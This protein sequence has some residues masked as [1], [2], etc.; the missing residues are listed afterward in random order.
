MH[1]LE[2]E[3]TQ[4]EADEAAQQEELVRLRAENERLS[5]RIV[6]YRAALNRLQKMVPDEPETE[7]GKGI[8][9]VAEIVEPSPLDAL[10][11]SHTDTI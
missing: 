2:F 8:E 3:F 6:H 1:S 10:Q 9:S 4:E 7:I 5:L 11:D